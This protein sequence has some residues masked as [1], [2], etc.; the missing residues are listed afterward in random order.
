MLKPIIKIKVI[1]HADR[2]R[3]AIDAEIRRHEIALLRALR[4]LRKRFPTQSIAVIDELAQKVVL[5]KENG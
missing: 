1:S 2:E 4:Q 5:T 3:S